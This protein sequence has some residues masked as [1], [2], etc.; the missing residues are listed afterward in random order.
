MKK[1]RSDN[2]K[3]RKRDIRPIIRALGREAAESLRSET[4]R[5]LLL[6]EESYIHFDPTA[7]AVGYGLAPA[8]A[9]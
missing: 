1:N 4:L 5:Y 9:G 6:N 2:T 8:P 7:Y 3:R